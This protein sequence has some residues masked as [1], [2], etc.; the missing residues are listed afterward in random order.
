MVKLLTQLTSRL[1]ETVEAWHEFQGKDVEYFLSGGSS[2]AESAA[3]RHSV[4][5]ISKAFAQLRVLRQ[6]LDRLRKELRDDN[7]QGVSHSL[8]LRTVSFSLIVAV[9]NYIRFMAISAWKTTKPR[10]SSAGPP[11]MSRS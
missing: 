11:A 1:Y 2:P 10:S 3:L 6:K 7:P 9:T 4:T 8:T 5:A